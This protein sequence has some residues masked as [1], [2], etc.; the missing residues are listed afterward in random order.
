MLTLLRSQGVP[1]KKARAEISPGEI[2]EILSRIQGEPQEPQ[3]SRLVLRSM[4][5]AQY[6]TQCSGHFGLAAEFYCHF[7]SHIRR[8]PDLQIHRIIKEHLRGRLDGRRISHYGE[9]LEEVARQCSV[10]DR[11]ADES[12]REVEKMKKAEYM[13]YHLGEIFQGVISSVTG[14]GFYV[15]LPNTVE[16]LVHVNTLRDDYYVY[17]SAR[18]ELTGELTRKTFAVGDAVT[19]RVADADCVTKTVDFVLQQE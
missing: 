11:R 5:Q 15:E 1:V 4:K 17:D 8:Y 16:G 13:S 2:Q 6:T 19:V 7:T 3:I 12:E 9:V 14:W 18:Q 10:T